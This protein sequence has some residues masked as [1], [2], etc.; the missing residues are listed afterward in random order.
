MEKIKKEYKNI[1]A[2]YTTYKRL[3]RELGKPERY[4]LDPQKIEEDLSSAE[5]F[6]LINQG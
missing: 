4:P 1:L 2:I 6:K 3:K 5:F